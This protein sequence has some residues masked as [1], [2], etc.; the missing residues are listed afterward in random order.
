MINY[1]AAFEKMTSI[2]LSALDTSE[3]T[4][5]DSMFY[6]CGSLLSLDVS[7]FNT[8]Q[9]T[10]MSRM[11]YEA[12]KN[13]SNF[14][15]DL[16]NFVKSSVTNIEYMFYKAGYNS[17]TFTL[18]GLNT[19]D[20]SNITK[21]SH[22]FNETAYNSASFNIGD[23]SNWNFSKTES[24]TGMRNIFSGVAHSATTFESIG[25]LVMPAMDNFYELFTLSPS[26][27]GN[28]VFTG[29][30]NW[31]SVAYSSATNS[32]ARV[33]LYYTDSTAQTNVEKIILRNGPNGTST[34]GNIYNMG[35]YTPPTE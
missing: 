3:V 7:N 27:T 6:Y 2:D 22:L 9:V 14:S 15:L 34:Q 1:F 5:M 13:V 20:T 16:T 12:G 17:N 19:W 4:D 23:L 35:Q 31:S 29:D 33:N 21:M 28:F 26:F 10:N 25:T 24:V 18:I 8:S 11:F 30:F 32:N